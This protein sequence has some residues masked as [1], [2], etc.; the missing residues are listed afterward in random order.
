MQH[1][2]GFGQ[3]KKDAS[4]K[5]KP[6]SEETQGNSSKYDYNKIQQWSMV[7]PINISCLVYSM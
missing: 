6:V 4:Q 1:P 2:A 5:L 3:H 7:F